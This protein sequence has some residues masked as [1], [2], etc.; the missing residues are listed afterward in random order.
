MTPG[1]IGGTKTVDAVSVVIDQGG[2]RV[3]HCVDQFEKTGLCRLLRLNVSKTST[4]N[5]ELKGQK[6]KLA[7]AF[8][9]FAVTGI[10]YS[11][12]FF[13]GIDLGLRFLDTL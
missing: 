8:F 10:G 1:S 3:G 11:L 13:R 4:R 6:R 7:Y 12:I 5:G 2:K 9:D